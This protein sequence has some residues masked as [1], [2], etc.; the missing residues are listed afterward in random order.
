MKERQK[1]HGIANHISVEKGILT[2][3]DD[4]VLPELF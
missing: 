2:Y 1:R 3:A 4:A